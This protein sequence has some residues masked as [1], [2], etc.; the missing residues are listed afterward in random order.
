MDPAPGVCRKRRKS[1]RT[2]EIRTKRG[3]KPLNRS[4]QNSDSDDTSEHSSTNI[5]SSSN[6]GLISFDR[7]SKPSRPQKYNFYVDL[8]KYKVSR[9]R[10]IRK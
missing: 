3:R 8:G 2:D 6:V 9:K 5:G 10:D 1:S 4:R 7:T